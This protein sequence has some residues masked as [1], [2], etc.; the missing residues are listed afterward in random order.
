M[1]FTKVMP[2]FRM[3]SGK[4]VLYALEYGKNKCLQFKN[5][6]LGY[7]YEWTLFLLNLKCVHLLKGGRRKVAIFIFSKVNDIKL[8]T[9]IKFTNK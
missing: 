5:I 7:V 6:L 4:N 9:V 3:I 8:C 2:M 1:V